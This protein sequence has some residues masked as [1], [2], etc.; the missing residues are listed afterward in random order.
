MASKQ[1]IAEKTSRRPWIDP[2][3]QGGVLVLLASLLVM[4][5]C[6]WWYRGGHRGQLIEI[7][8]AAPLEARFRVD[9]NE[10]DW[11]EIIQ[12]PG[13]GEVLAKRV[14]AERS[15]NGPFRDVDDLVRVDG[16]GAKTLEEIRPYLLP[17]SADSDWAA[18]SRGDAEP[19]P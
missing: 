5:I 6:F 8:R 14:L 11:P 9:I 3:D 4:T 2:R 12:L 15:D 7:D 16:I 17:I 18:T 19:A 10:A 13:L 1:P